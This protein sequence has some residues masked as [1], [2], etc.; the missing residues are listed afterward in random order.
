MISAVLD[1]KA[2]WLEDGETTGGGIPGW[3]GSIAGSLRTD[4][5]NYTAGKTNHLFSSATLNDI[6]AA[7]MPYMNAI[8]QIIA[9]NQITEGGPSTH[10]A[11]PR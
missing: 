8:S 10:K 3:A 4:N 7:W 9:R 1:S 6:F 5:E 2:H 11:S